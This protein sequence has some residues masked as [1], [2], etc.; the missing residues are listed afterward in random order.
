MSADL[1]RFQYGL[2][3]L[4]RQRQWKLDALLRVLGRLQARIQAKREALGSLRARLRATSLD[5][6][7]A[8]NRRLDPLRHAASLKWLAR[9]HKELRASEAELAQLRMERSRVKARIEA[10]QQK[11]DVLE[12]H[13]EE[14][15]ADFSREE[16]GR[17][18]TEADRDWLVRATYNRQARRSDQ[19]GGTP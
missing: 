15:L 8:L 9:L 16:S 5:A 11:V 3:P 10:L 12:A 2:E 7:Q 6:A 13:R 1:R 18:A 4:L 19:E 14:S 17:L